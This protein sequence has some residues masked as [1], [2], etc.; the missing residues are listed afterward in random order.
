MNFANE[1]GYSPLSQAGRSVD[2][3]DGDI[4]LEGAFTRGSDSSA[5]PIPWMTAIAQRAA[6]I[7]KF[8]WITCTWRIARGYRTI[9]GRVSKL[10]QK[11]D[12]HQQARPIDKS[13]LHSPGPA[14]GQ[15]TLAA[16]DN[17]PS[18]APT[19]HLGYNNFNSHSHVRSSANASELPVQP[20]ILYAIATRK[21]RA[22]MQRPG[23]VQKFEEI[24]PCA[25]CCGWPMRLTP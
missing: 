24:S 12:A 22:R 18:V 10:T 9:L 4:A 11:C 13:V 23:F 8:T 20:A 16:G 19:M 3:L 5:A 7:L 2:W 6:T 1:I 17:F 15:S 21:T 25:L 14:R